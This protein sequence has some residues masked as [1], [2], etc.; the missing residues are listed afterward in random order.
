M[1][2]LLHAGLFLD[3]LRCAGC[4]NRTERALR[5]AEGV[6][7]ANVNYTNHR[8]W[9]RFEARELWGE[10]ARGRGAVYLDLWEPH[11]ESAA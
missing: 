3:G 11:L 2:C 9:V 10:S 1:F 4:V 6:R 7:E 8:A 5:A